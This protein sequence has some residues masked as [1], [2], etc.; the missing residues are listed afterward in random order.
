MKAFY[1]LLFIPFTLDKPSTPENLSM[2]DIT[3][4]SVSLKW[5]EPRGDIG[6]G[7]TGYVIE[8]RDVR[9]NIWT[10]AGTV[11][12]DQTSYTVNKLMEGSDYL[13][14]VAAENQ[15]G[16]GDFVE[17]REPI[18]VELPYCKYF[19]YTIL[20]NLSHNYEFTALS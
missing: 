2:S 12:P 11:G 6:A 15:L 7:I 16:T 14:R 3:R 20:I 17:L 1:I 10:T 18:T 8:K 5:D 4:E 9:R 19:W 13:F